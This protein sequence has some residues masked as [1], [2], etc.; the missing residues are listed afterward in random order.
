MNS[1]THSA[2]SMDDNDDVSYSC[3]HSKCQK[4]PSIHPTIHQYIHAVIHI[5]YV[6]SII[7]LTL[8]TCRSAKLMITEEVFGCSELFIEYSIANL[9]CNHEES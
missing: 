7:I 8:F 4:H 9:L 2:R 5:S 6:Y 1:M 3:D